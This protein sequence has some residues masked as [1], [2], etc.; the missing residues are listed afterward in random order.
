MAEE[1]Y[2]LGETKLIFKRAGPPKWFFPSKGKIKISRLRKRLLNYS[3]NSLDL[4][5]HFSFPFYNK[6]NKISI[7]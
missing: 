2:N 6:I 3:K 7:F 5:S 4:L 1:S